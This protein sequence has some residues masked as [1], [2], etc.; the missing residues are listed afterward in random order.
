MSYLLLKSIVFED[1]KGNTITID[2][3]GPIYFKDLF[4]N[5]ESSAC[6]YTS[7]IISASI[8]RLAEFLEQEK[9]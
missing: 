5:T 1:S 8:T 6:F 3:P 4:D 2:S 9:E 7:V